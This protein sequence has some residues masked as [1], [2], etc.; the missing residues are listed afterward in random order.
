VTAA[1]RKHLGDF[2]AIVALFFLVMLAQL[3]SRRFGIAET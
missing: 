2:L 1:I 3:A